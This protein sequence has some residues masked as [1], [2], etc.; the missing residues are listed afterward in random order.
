MT[1]LL[2][3]QPQESR[4][5]VGTNDEIFACR[6][7]GCRACTLAV[8]LCYSFA[9]RSECCVDILA[10]PRSVKAVGCVAVLYWRPV[11]NFIRQTAR[12]RGVSLR[13]T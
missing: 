6:E 13:W 7:A 10:R 9:S 1:E 8:W 3:S 2:C 12:A 11:A 4:V 5:V